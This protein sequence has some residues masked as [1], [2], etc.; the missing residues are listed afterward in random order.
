MNVGE[1]IGLLAKERNMNLHQLAVKADVPYSTVYALVSRKSKRIEAVTLKK[2]AAALSVSEREITGYYPA[3]TVEID[4]NL[5]TIISVDPDWPCLVDTYRMLNS[6]GQR[7]ALE[8]I[9]ELLEI[10]RYRRKNDDPPE[11]IKHFIKR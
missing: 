8:R 3:S 7:K 9:E 5:D 4:E 6:E 10:P 2:I 1:Q 11:D